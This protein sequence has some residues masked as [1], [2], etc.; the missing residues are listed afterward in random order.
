MIE[1][2]VD[3]AFGKNSKGYEIPAWAFIVLNDEEEKDIE[4]EEYG[5]EIPAVYFEHRNVAGE[6]YSVKKLIEFCQ[7]ND[8]KEVLIHNDYEGLEKW[9]TGEWKTNKELTKIY[10][11]FLDNSGVNIKWEKVEAHT[12]HKW[13]EYVDSLC[14]RALEEDVTETETSHTP[15]TEISEDI[16]VENLE[17]PVEVIFN[18]NPPE[19]QTLREKFRIKTDRPINQNVAEI[20]EEPKIAENKIE[21]PKITEEKTETTEFKTES[22]K[23][24]DIQFD[25]LINE[26]EELCVK[27]KYMEASQVLKPYINKD[28]DERVF[29]AYIDII[30]FLGDFYAKKAVIYCE[31]YIPYHPGTRVRRSYCYA[32]FYAYIRP[33]TAS[34]HFDLNAYNEA[35]NAAWKILNMSKNSKIINEFLYPL[36]EYAFRISD[37]GFIKNILK[38]FD[39][40]L[41]SKEKVKVG[42][43][44]LFSNFDRINY[45]LRGM[46]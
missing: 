46:Q 36:I 15:V 3:G 43:R 7:E 5:S 41:F 4:Y 38:E 40:N 27:H 12:G 37:K 23:D 22:F 35:K 2:Y 17:P 31:A 6:I 45:M 33:I 28:S 16:S 30:L 19:D 21:E 14:K 32:L 25:A 1:A 20:H 13:N 42:S 26:A 11:E 39:I 9:A 34:H 24:T 8:E 29:K 10:K 44:V 18:T